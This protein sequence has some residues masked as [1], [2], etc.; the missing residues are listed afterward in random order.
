MEAREQWE[1]AAASAEALVHLQPPW[2]CWLWPGAAPSILSGELRAYGKPQHLGK[3][4]EEMTL[5]EEPVQTF[6]GKG[7]NCHKRE[8]WGEHDFQDMQVLLD[9]SGKWV[10]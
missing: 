7:E 4:E 10:L 6:E 8:A 2:S 9:S 1:A 3:L 5:G